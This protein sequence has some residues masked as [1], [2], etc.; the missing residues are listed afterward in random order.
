[1]GRKLFGGNIVE[2]IRFLEELFEDIQ[3]EYITH[4]DKA[5]QGV[6]YMSQIG[7][8]V[9]FIQRSGVKGEYFGVRESLSRTF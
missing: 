6:H 4:T 1:M 2:G 9:V 7:I 3:S 8:P 5:L